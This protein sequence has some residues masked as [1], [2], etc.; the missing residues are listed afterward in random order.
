M[1]LYD[2]RDEG[3]AFGSCCTIDDLHDARRVSA[4]LGIPHYVVNFERQFAARV[5]DDFVDEYLAGRTPL[6]CARCNT[7]LKFSELVARAEAMGASH[8]ATGHYARVESDADTGRFRLLRGRDREK[9]QSYFLFGLTQAQLSR[10]LFP[11][12]HLD[13]AAVRREA[14]RLSLE[15]AG[16]RDSH[17]LCFVTAG[18]HADFVAGRAARALDGPITDAGGK[19][20]GR[21][22]GIQRFTVGQRKGLG[23]SGRTPLYVIAIEP[24]ANRVVVGERAELSCSGLAATEVNWVA[25]P[26]PAMPRRLSVQIRYRHRAAPATVHADGERTLVEFDEPQAAVAPGQA[27]VFYD[28]DEVIGGGWIERPH[29]CGGSAPAQDPAVAAAASCSSRER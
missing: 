4:R 16:K 5:V 18:G 21:H 26:R 19:V 17:E 3:A 15:V 14:R 8:V 1:Q 23:L 6:P 12:G 11:V 22:T 29:R 25:G 27:A 2:Q 7:D 20:L 24:E 9:D 28:G 13:K 10:A